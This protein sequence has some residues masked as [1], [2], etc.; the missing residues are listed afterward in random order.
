MDDTAD[1]IAVDLS[2]QSRWPQGPSSSEDSWLAEIARLPAQAW[3]LR[4]DAGLPP[5]PD[6]E[7]ILVRDIDG[8]RTT[9]YVGE[10]RHRGRTLRI[11][12]R[13]GAEVVSGWIGTAHNVRIFDRAAGSSPSSA[14]ILIQ[15]AA[16][17]WRA[18]V[19]DAGQHALPRTRTRRSVISTTVHGRL[20]APGTAR[21][22]AA[23]DPR[24]V[25][26]ERLR[27]LDN[28]ATA[29]VLCADRVLGRHLTG[30]WRGPLIEDHLTRMRAAVGPRPALPTRDAL[31][32]MRYTPLTARWRRAADLSW[33]IATLN[34][35]RRSADA[36]TT[37]GVL[38]DVAELWELFLLRC[39]GRATDRLVTH[40][41]RA[42]SGRRLL[43]SLDDP[44]RG[45][46]TLYPD[47]LVDPSP[48]D[49]RRVIDAKY[50]RLSP[51]RPVEPEDLYQLAAYATSFEA[52]RAMLA[53]PHV[54]HDVAD[55]ER[56]GPWSGPG[57]SIYEFRCLP[58]TERACIDWFGAW[59]SSSS[60]TGRQALG[61]GGT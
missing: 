8:W 28:A 4:V 25:S 32:R 22:R 7:P 34:L 53:Y 31:R 37:S 16:A 56:R 39:V 51:H 54:G 58:V 21:L 57:T 46:G 2:P 59:M 19:L 42:Y 27:T 11:E 17:M 47:A 24:I 26:V 23:G 55:A 48:D 20:D 43:A 18:A 61:V 13:L 49:G 30:P 36:E 60:V 45:M 12:P 15:L 14:P 41:T 5:A 38:V 9:R 33:R 35:L 40:G 3:V 10:I 6:D 50:K 44:S 1:V 29:A 52:A